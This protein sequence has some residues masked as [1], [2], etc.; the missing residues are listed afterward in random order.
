MTVTYLAS[1]LVQKSHAV[2]QH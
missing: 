2:K 1:A